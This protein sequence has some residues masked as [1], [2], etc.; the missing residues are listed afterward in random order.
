M[1]T[2]IIALNKSQI[3]SLTK[4]GALLAIS[5]V[6]PLF[7][8]QI[9][10]GPIV[11][12]ML[13]LAVLFLP[14]EGALML[15]LLPSLIALSVGALPVALAPMV[16]FIMT[17]NA[18]LVMAFTS[19]KKKNFMAA[20]IFASFLK[21]IFLLLTSYL[22]LELIT[23]KQIAQKVAQMM[24][25]PQLITALTGGLLAFIILKCLKKT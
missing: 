22:V 9:I 23:Q 1:Q 16:P 11:N 4:F 10:T 25:Y 5:V 21:F 17:S 8:F 2:K 12:A 3:I 7:H 20:V 15:C 18:I 6:A 13:F 19:L 14:I 24:S